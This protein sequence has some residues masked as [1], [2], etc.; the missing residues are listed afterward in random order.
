MHIIKDMQMFATALY[1]QFHGRLQKIL[2]SMTITRRKLKN[3]LM[4]QAGKRA[5]MDLD[6]RM[7]RNLQFI[8]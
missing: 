8:G 5:L 2:T 4:Q 7:E 1:H 6:T 3:Y